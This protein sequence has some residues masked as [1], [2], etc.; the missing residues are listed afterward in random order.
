MRQLEFPSGFQS[1]RGDKMNERVVSD[2]RNR[3]VELGLTESDIADHIGLSVM[4]Y[5]DI[6]SYPDEIYTVVDLEKVKRL[7]ETL[8]LNF[9]KTLGIE[10]EFCLGNG[11]YRSI[12]TLPRH[13]IIR[14]SRED[15]KLSRKVLGDHIAFEEATVDDMEHNP[16]FLESW[17]IDYIRVLS[18]VLSVPLQILMDV[19]CSDCGK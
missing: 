12:Y 11:V 16:A 13:M 7:F 10:C 14:Q 17:P 18:K 15:L 2:L 19:K 6:E 9:L 8:G 5:H 3:R 4:E 1:Q